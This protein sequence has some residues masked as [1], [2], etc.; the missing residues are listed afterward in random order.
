M[1]PRIYEEIPCPLDGYDLTLTLLAN[2]T[3]AEKSAWWRSNLGDPGC[4]DCASL[5]ES[6]AGAFC[7]KCSAAR[8]AFGQSVMAIFQRIGDCDLSTPAACVHAIEETIPDEL[9]PWLYQAPTLLWTGRSEAI[10]K[11]LRPSLTTGDSTSSLDG[12]T[13]PIESIAN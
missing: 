8:L 10:K 4:A 1:F 5:Q 3:G 9:I 2:P 11:K 7:P 12:V 13:R 6:D